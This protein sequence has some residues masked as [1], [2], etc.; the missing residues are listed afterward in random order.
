M[1]MSQTEIGIM[2]ARFAQII[3]DNAPMTTRR[4]VELCQQEMN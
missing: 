1:K 3:W 2:E 4:M